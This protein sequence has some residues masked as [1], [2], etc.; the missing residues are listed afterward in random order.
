[1]NPFAEL[2]AIIANFYAH[3][4]LLRFFLQYLSADFYNPLSQFIVT[5]TNPLLRFLRKVIPGYKGLD[6]ASLALA[7]LTYSV[8]YI[9]ISLL[10]GQLS[11]DLVML[12]V[13]PIF[14]VIN[15]SFWLFIILIFIRAILSWIQLGHNPYTLLLGQ[16]TNPLINKV[17]RRL[18]PMSGLDLSPMVATI[19]LYFIY[20]LLNVYIFAPILVGMGYPPVIL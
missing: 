6:F 12:L 17:R 7:F 20:R 13:V 18:P 14:K 10:S 2:V 1:M 4:V 15:S 19:G 16:L 8:S 5:V 11:L 3:F 9:L